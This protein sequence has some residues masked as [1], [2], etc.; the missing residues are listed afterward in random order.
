MPLAGTRFTHF[1]LSK[2]L[3]LLIALLTLLLSFPLMND[4]SF[5]K[6]IFAFF[7]FF[8]LLGM[9]YGLKGNHRIVLF[10]LIGTIV[11]C[12]S[13]AEIRYHQIYVWNKILSI[14]FNVYAITLFCK[15]IY[16]RKQITSDILIGSLCVYL[17]IGICFAQLYMVIQAFSSHALIHTINTL[18]IYN[19]ED[20]YYF[21]FITLATVGF[22]DILAHTPFS[23]SVVMIEG[24]VGIFYIAIM[25]ARLVSA[26][27]TKKTIS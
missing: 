10:M 24:Q 3:A 4:Q 5:G 25:V 19:Q 15:D 14:L 21:S 1:L 18:P 27:N 8:I 20:F 17:L 26:F 16:T 7:F 13:I 2:Y 12:M 23:K 22:G 9:F 11:L 6:V